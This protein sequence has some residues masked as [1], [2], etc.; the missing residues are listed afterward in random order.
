MKKLLDSAHDAAGVPRDCQFMGLAASEMGRLAS[1][2]AYLTERNMDEK[3][4]GV[5]RHVLT[6]AG[7]VMVYMGWTDDATWT[8]VMGSLMVMVPMVWSWMSK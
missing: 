5:I 8:T 1:E 7:A 4:L 3:K 2:A 6:A